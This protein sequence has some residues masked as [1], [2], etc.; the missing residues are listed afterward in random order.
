MAKFPGFGLNVQTPTVPGFEHIGEAF[1]GIATQVC[2]LGFSELTVN[3][4]SFRLDE[5][6]TY[7]EEE[8]LGEAAA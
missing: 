4:I 1:F 7:W 3:A 2:D 8:G 5:A 6:L